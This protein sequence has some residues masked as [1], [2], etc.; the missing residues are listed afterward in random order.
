M[1]HDWSPFIWCMSMALSCISRCRLRKSIKMVSFDGNHTSS[2]SD[3]EKYLTNSHFVVTAVIN[4]WFLYIFCI[5]S[6][7]AASQS[8]PYSFRSTLFFNSIESLYSDWDRTRKKK[9]KKNINIDFNL[10]ELWWNAYTTHWVRCFWHGMCGKCVCGLG[11]NDRCVLC[12][13]C[14]SCSVV[15]RLSLSWLL[16]MNGECRVLWPQMAWA[17]CHCD[18]MWYS[19]ARS[20]DAQPSSQCTG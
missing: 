1:H 6:Q 17:H 2:P 8:F 5:L 15:I 3:D 19:Q 12:A 10:N 14:T 7:L 9:N 18:E 13:V 11:C 16:R 20:L 4:Y